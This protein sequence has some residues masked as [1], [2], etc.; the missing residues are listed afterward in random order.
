MWEMH[1]SELANRTGG[2]VDDEDATDALVR[3]KEGLKSANRAVAGLRLLAIDEYGA[4]RDDEED[5]AAAVA[6]LSV[7]AAAILLD[8]A[9]T[10]DAAPD[11]QC[12]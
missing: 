3:A 2:E 5:A 11:T 6:A 7:E 1:W 4:T 12:D 8:D 10:G 9:A